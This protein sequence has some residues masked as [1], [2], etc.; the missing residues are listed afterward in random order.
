MP[1]YPV[2]LFDFDGTLVDTHGVILD[3]YRH[4]ALEVLGEELPADVVEANLSRT[5]REAAADVAGERAEDFFRVYVEH[6]LALH[7]DEVGPFEGVTEMLMRLRDDGRR[8]GIV[9]SKLRA[10]VDLVLD[11][12]SY[13]PAF[14]VIVTVDDTDAHKPEPDPILLALERM[15]VGPDAAIY[16]GDSPYDI[17]AARAAGVASGAALW[18]IHAKDDLL[19]L[20]PDHVFETPQEVYAG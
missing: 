6:S 15:N 5:L 20:W 9:T 2:W 11:T 10:T 1:A 16:V 4:A 7:A 3:C 13:G 8:L 18:G 17:L 12:I 14:E 19:E